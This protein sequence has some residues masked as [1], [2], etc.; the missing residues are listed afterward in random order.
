MTA[1]TEGTC[2]PNALPAVN[3]ADNQMR[4]LQML[5]AHAVP[6]LINSMLACHSR[7]AAGLLCILAKEQ[8]CKEAFLEESALKALVDCL[9]GTSPETMSGSISSSA[10]ADQEKVH[11]A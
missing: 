10:D 8:Q 1:D 3:P 7:T 6:M 11:E 9:S 5:E 4:D 2:S